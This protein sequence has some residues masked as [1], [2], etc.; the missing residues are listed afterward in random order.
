VHARAS[1]RTGE[2]PAR[3]LL[4]QPLHLAL[5]RAALLAQLLRARAVAALVRGVRVV[6]R[7][8]HRVPCLVRA[9]A[10]GRVLRVA[11]VDLVLVLQGGA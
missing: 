2:D 9:R 7:A 10:E 11:R 6:E 4:V 1:A 8:R 5:V 3:G